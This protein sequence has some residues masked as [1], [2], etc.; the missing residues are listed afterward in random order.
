MFSCNHIP[1]CYKS[2]RNRDIKRLFSFS[3][4]KV[5]CNSY[6]CYLSSCISPQMPHGLAF[7]L[8]YW[9]QTIW[10]DQ[11]SLKCSTL[12]CFLLIIYVNYFHINVKIPC[13]LDSMTKNKEFLEALDVLS[14]FSKPLAGM[15]LFLLLLPPLPNRALLFLSSNYLIS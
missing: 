5:N 1:L 11:S 3:N 7:F 4:M 9:K 6:K 13:F 8:Y 2:S 15:R 12:T 10:L 14:K